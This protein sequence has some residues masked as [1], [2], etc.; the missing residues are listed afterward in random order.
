MQIG[1]PVYKTFLV[2]KEQLREESV[3]W[4][5]QPIA[6]TLKSQFIKAGQKKNRR[7]SNGERTKS[8]GTKQGTFKTENLLIGLIFNFIGWQRGMKKYIPTLFLE[9]LLLYHSSAFKTQ[10][11]DFINYLINYNKM[12]LLG[13]EPCTS[14][15]LVI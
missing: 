13:I 15:R 12:N 8:R 10:C 6:K 5:A 14:L 4:D 3:Q 1:T 2:A 9:E 11:I 7:I